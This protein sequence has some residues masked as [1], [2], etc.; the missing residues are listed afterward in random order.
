M[1]QFLDF[2]Q[3]CIGHHLAVGQHG[4]AVADGVQRVQVVGDQEHG[5]PQRFLQGP[6]QAVERGR[7]DR[8][9]AGGG[10]VQEQQ[11]WI[12]RQRAGQAGALAHAAGQLRRQLVIA[13]AG[14]PAS[15][16]FSSASS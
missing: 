2:R 1:I 3:R 7:A 14:R 16:T 12:Q 9:E 5:Q 15:F 4:N 6:D 13:S 10:F 11:R 8:V